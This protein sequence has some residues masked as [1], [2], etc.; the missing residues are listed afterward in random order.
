MNEAAALERAL[1]AGRRGAW[2]EALVALEAAWAVAK[3]PQL[4]EVAWA[5]VQS[6]LGAAPIAERLERETEAA[7]LEA[8][9]RGDAELLPRLVSTPWPRLTSDARARVN[10][11]VASAPALLWTAYLAAFA[12]GDPYQSQQSAL[13]TR[14]S[15]RWLLKHGDPMAGR[16]LDGFREGPPDF[17]LALGALGRRG[18]P[19]ALPLAPAAQGAL[20][21]LEALVRT[22]PRDVEA[23]TREVYA[24]PHDDGRRAVLADA[25]TEAGDPRGEF[26]GLQLAR[27]PEKHA[28]RLSELLRSHGRAWLSPLAPFIVVPPSGLLPIFSRGF[29][30]NVRVDWR[31]T[32]EIFGRTEA[33]GTVET[34]TVSPGFAFEHHPHL[35]GLRRLRGPRDAGTTPIPPLEAALVAADAPLARLPFTAVAELGVIASWS[36]RAAVERALGRWASGA[37]WFP[38]V[39]S[40]RVPGTVRDLPFARTLLARFPSVDAVACALEVTGPEAAWPSNWELR[41]DRANVLT[42][43]WHGRNW[44]G[45]PPEEV[46]Q[47]LTAAFVQGLARVEIVLAQKLPSAQR[48]RLWTALELARVGWPGEPRLSVAA[49]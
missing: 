18:A 10:V 5:I 11:I 36:D 4:A 44:S 1:A 9:G 43:T 2:A 29:P 33:W 7:W 12:R 42:L 45:A 3:H 37:A 19:A 23:L 26:I 25:L 46:G 16:L 31:Q 34:L 39:R 35:T 14:L 28:R 22:T 47:W 38:S 20:E 13:I 30:A 17:R 8:A 6:R 41:L 32:P 40:L 21:Q 48:A 24:H 49:G 27:A 15:L